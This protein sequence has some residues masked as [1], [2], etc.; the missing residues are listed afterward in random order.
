MREPG[1]YWVHNGNRW[2]VAEWFDDDLWL[3]PGVENALY[4]C[5]LQ[6]INENR[7]TAPA[8]DTSVK[9]PKIHELKVH[10]DVWDDLWSGIKTWEY[11][12]NDRNYE[13]GDVLYLRKIDPKTGNFTAGPCDYLHK[14]VTYIL[15]GP[16]FGIH[17]EYCIMSIQ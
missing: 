11:R 10:P 16:S 4:D 15:Y 3:M 6:E 8:T 12:V 7:L 5:D 13:V 2:V 9:M 17:D 1:F 14:R